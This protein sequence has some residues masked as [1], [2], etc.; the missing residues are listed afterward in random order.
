MVAENRLAAIYRANG[1]DALRLAFLLTGNKEVAEDITQDAFVRLG[2]KLFR[3]RDR[4]H[5]RAYLLRIVINLAKGRG[6]RLVR[7]QSALQK[8][9]PSS[10]VP[11]PDLAQHDDLWNA[12]KSLPTRQRAALYLRYYLDL[13]QAQAAIS[14]G[15][16]ESA[17]K[18]LVT[19]GLKSVRNTLV[20]EGDE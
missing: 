12:L 8:L 6:R 1:S 3:F 15:C 20:G 14:L 19:R 17:M 7:E 11:P 2:G 9:R 5:E 18:S 16:S 13:T 10:T 4:D